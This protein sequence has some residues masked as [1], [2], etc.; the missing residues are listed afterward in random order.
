MGLLSAIVGTVAGAVLGS[1]SKSGAQVGYKETNLGKPGISSEFFVGKGL[2]KPK[3]RNLRSAKLFKPTF[4]SF[5]RKTAAAFA[6]LADQDEIKNTR[7]T[8]KLFKALS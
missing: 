1:K 4:Y 3:S 6:D 7:Y 5:D 2:R 8:K